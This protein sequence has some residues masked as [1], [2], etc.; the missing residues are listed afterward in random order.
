MGAPPSPLW[1][2]SGPLDLGKR[3]VGLCPG[4]TN[5]GAC[6]AAERR[7]LGPRPDFPR[8]G[9]RALGTV[10]A[11]EACRTQNCPTW[12]PMGSSPAWGNQSLS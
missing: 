5:M 7:V 9:Q 4:L 3:R 8:A 1:E 12:E 2:R 10:C 11:G 6:G